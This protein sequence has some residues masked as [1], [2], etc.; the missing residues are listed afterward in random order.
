MGLLGGSIWSQVPSL[1]RAVG[2]VPP[3]AP[4]GT[5]PFQ[6]QPRTTHSGHPTMPLPWVGITHSSQAGHCALE[7]GDTESS[8]QL[9]TPW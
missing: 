2:L 6:P 8:H 5:T 9:S 7:R 3:H 1:T 4:L